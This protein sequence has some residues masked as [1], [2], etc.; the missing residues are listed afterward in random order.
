MG[1]AL[2]ISFHSSYVTFFIPIFKLI[3]FAY[4]QQFTSFLSL[5]YLIYKCHFGTFRAYC[6]TVTHSI[7]AIRRE[8]PVRKFKNAWPSFML[9]P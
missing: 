4:H 1:E 9:N 5:Y 3:F 6:L 8:T 7:R 2:C